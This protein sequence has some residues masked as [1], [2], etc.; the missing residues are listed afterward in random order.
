[1]QAAGRLLL[2]LALITVIGLLASAAFGQRNRS[3]RRAGAAGCLGISALDCVMLIMVD[4]TVPV[5]IWPVILASAASA[6]CL[7]FTTPALRAVL[8]G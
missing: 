4:F 6:A 1:M 3:A 5:L 2:G 8:T 7:T